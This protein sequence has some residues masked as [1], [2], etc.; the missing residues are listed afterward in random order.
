MYNKNTLLRFEKAYNK[1]H[2]EL[3]KMD[4]IKCWERL[5]FCVLYKAQTHFAYVHFNK[6]LRDTYYEAGT[7]LSTPV[8]Q[9]LI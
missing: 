1:T 7:P 9:R 5:N 4:K 3:L 8:R 6:H 2:I